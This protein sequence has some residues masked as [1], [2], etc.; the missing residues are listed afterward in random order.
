MAKI[1][2]A[3]VTEHPSP[4]QVEFFNAISKREELELQVIY[5]RAKNPNRL[6][7]TESIHHRALALDGDWS[8]IADCQT[9][10]TQADLFVLNFYTD[11]VAQR[12]LDARVRA[13]KTWT[14]WGERPGFTRWAKIGP[15]YRRWKLRHLHNTPHPI[16]G[17]GKMAVEAYRR[18]FRNDRSYFNLPY[19]SNLDRFT[20]AK[21]TGRKDPGRT[22]LY[23]GSLISRKG[24]D[25][26]A[27]AFVELLRQG[28][29]VTLRLMGVGPLEPELRRLFAPCGDC[30]QFLG[31]VAWEDIPTA[32]RGAD[33]MCVP[34]RHD[35]WG[36][37]VPEGLASGLPVVSTTH[38]GA[39]VEL[40]KTRYNGWLVPGGELQPLIQ[41]LEEA[42]R[43]SDS[44]LARMSENAEASV[45][46]HS[47][48]HGVQRFTEAVHSA[49]T[50]RTEPAIA[51]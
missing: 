31:F 5:L 46:E 33:I 23:S 25:L 41:A 34:S 42:A 30:V 18:E 6:W 15:W 10:V 29:R 12:F 45:A 32:C 17:I 37:V 7:K 44:E 51:K 14:F 49:L 36:L 38:T 24:V 3:V 4:Y 21:R 28:H 22:I 16:W 47:L 19:F 35:G 39:A 26:L 2:V 8:R 13:A 27:K 43:L 1:S 50:R 20:S 40:V 48:Q 9:S 11:S